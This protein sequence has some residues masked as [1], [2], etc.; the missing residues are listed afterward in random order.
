MLRD[1]SLSG[2]TASS[3]SS[4]LVGTKPR[5][6]VPNIPGQVWAELSETGIIRGKHQ[7]QKTGRSGDGTRLSPPTL[8][9]LFSWLPFWKPIAPS[10]HW[11]PW[12]LESWSHKIPFQ[13]TVQGQRV[14]KGPAGCSLALQNPTFCIGPLCL[15]TLPSASRL[16]YLLLDLSQRLGGYLI[17]HFHTKEWV[18]LLLPVL[19]GHLYFLAPK[20]KT[21]MREF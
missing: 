5:F 17:K 9:H 21:L 1:G 7:I 8:C 15:Q 4:L 20:N 11:N 3:Q 2:P 16:I 12:L 6:L 19:W 18:K 13:R 10:S 14:F